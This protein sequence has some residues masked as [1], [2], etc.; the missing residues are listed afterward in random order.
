MLD[1]KQ[2]KR[3]S[4]RLSLHL[5]HDPKGLG[6]TLEKGGWVDVDTLLEAFTKK[7]FLV[8]LEEL[9][10]VVKDNEKQRFGFDETGTKIRAHQG[11]S[12]KI[13]LQLEP[14]SPPTTLYHGTAQHSLD[15][16]L[17]EGLKP[18]SRQHVHL[19]T[20]IKTMMEVARRHGKPV[21]LEIDAEKMH[22]SSHQFYQSDNGV[23]LTDFVPT[24]YLEVKT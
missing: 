20:N 12:V 22:V 5:R 16:I 15:A 13:D 1:K 10:E 8:S 23:W 6:I 4:K 11:H 9:Q 19:S 17:K 24:D 7:H 2:Q 18:M 3:I 21:L 14:Q